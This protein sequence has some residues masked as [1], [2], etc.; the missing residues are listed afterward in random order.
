V[1]SYLPMSL[2]APLA[3]L[4]GLL[5]VAAPI[6]YLIVLDLLLMA[7]PGHWRVSNVLVDP[8]DVVVAGLGVA[9]LLRARPRWQ[10]REQLPSRAFWALWLALGCLLCA[11]YLA[12]PENQPHLTDPI[13]IS[14]Q[15]YRYCWKTILYL[16]L[17]VVVLGDRKRAQAALTAIVLAGDLMAIKAIPQGYHGLRAAG[18]FESPNTLG[19]ML[20]LP[21]VVCIAGW[22]GGP[23]SLVRRAF[24]TASLLL[25]GR[26]LLF[27]G[28]RGALAAACLSAAV[29]VWQYARRPIGRRRVVRAAA[30]G[31]L[32]ALLGV[33]LFPRLLEGPNMQRFFTLS[34]AT[35]EETFQW[36]LHQRWPHFWR[37]IEAH[38]W[39]GTGT[40]VDLSLG[41]TGNT[42]HNGY[43]AL[44][45]M[46]GLPALAVTIVLS[47]AAVRRALR[48]L[49]PDLPPADWSISALAAAGLVGLLVHNVD[50]TVL[51]I[52]GI[53]KMH[54]LLVGL[55]VAPPLA[56]AVRLRREAA[57]EPAP[58][59]VVVEV[60]PQEEPAV[61]GAAR[62]GGEEPAAAGAARRGEETTARTGAARR[63]GEA[64]A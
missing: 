25:L 53:S 41:Q 19:A 15:L 40:Y 13:R 6:H 11:A 61:A 2:F 32:V 31:V 54:W 58:G 42:P 43:L 27:S 38:P 44:G 51:L 60:P 4:V 62:W 10:G 52:P 48:R 59:A 3:A 46:S 49:R 35:D 21:M 23:A 12:A 36:R 56:A 45:V 33:A 14:Y 8:T 63:G 5:A 9:L 18:P 50:D 7:L 1:E 20:I 37:K 57:A 39:L 17:A 34:H 64:P 24:W 47:L 22:L 28:S 29:L 30:A 55:A 26:A 16:P